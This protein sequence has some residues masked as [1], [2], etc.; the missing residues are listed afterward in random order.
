MNRNLLAVCLAVPGL[1]GAQSPFHAESASSIAVTAKED[2]RSVTIH[3]V[4][5]QYTG[6]RIPARPEDERLALRI[7]THEEN[8]LGDIPEPGMVTLEAWP[9]GTDPRQRPLYEIKVGGSQAHTVDDAIWVVDRGMV[10][11]PMWSVYKL[12]TGQHLFDTYVDM[13]RF[14]ITKDVQTPRYVGLEVPPDDAEDARLKEPHV[15]AV[16]SY[17]SE[18]RV[19]REVLLT[20]ANPERARDLRAYEDTG[21]TISY[22]ALPVKAVRIRFAP[23][24]GGGAATEVT[25][26]VKDDDLY[27]AGARLPP[28]MRLTTFRR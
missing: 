27:P 16:L 21:R 7:T 28:G 23:G 14:S 11:V 19:I 9:L 3:N 8:I 6:T 12:G 22:V 17:A 18:N 1:A 2:Y 24:V 4:T 13:L 25:V 5:Y 20:H 26:P 15:V 10:D